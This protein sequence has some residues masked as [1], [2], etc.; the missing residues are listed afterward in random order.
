MK[1]KITKIDKYYK[2]QISAMSSG[3][4]VIGEIDSWADVI[5]NSPLILRNAYYEKV[6]KKVHDTLLVV[7]KIIAITDNSEHE[8]FET[9][10]GFYEIKRI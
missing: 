6:P 9:A 2:E 3:D 5:P 4:S 7:S 10:F 1:V 8:Y